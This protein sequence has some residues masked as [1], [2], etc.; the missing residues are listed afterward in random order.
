MKLRTSSQIVSITT[1]FF[2]AFGGFAKAQNANQVTPPSASSDIVYAIPPAPT[3]T[4]PKRGQQY[5]VRDITVSGGCQ[6]GNTVNIYGGIVGAPVH[7]NCVANKFTRNV[8]LANWDGARR[9]RF[10]QTN[11]DGTS[12][13]DSR[14]VYLD[15]VV[16]TAPTITAP[17]NNSTHTNANLTVRGACETNAT[18]TIAGGILNSPVRFKCANAQYSR[19]VSLTSTNGSKTIRL[20]QK[21]VAGNVSPNRSIAV[22]LNVQT[23]GN[24]N[25]GPRNRSRILLSGHSLVD[26][27]LIDYVEDIAQKT[28]NNFNYNQQIVIGSPIRVR[29]KGMNTNASGWPGYST[30]KNKNTDNLNLINEVRNPQTLG[31]GEKYDTLVI[32]ENHS[33]LSQIQ[34]ENTIKY[35]RHYQDLMIAGNPATRSFF[36]HSWL[37][38]N[39]SNPTPWINHEKN[40]AVTWECVASKVNESLQSLNRT[41]RIRL[42]PS[43]GAL[44]D[45]VEKVV[46]GQVPGFTGSTSARLN[47]IFSDN[48]HLTNLGAYY[49]ALVVFSSVYGKSAVG[50]TP[51]AGSNVSNSIAQS[52]QTIAWNYVNAYYSQAGNPTA[53]TMASCRTFIANNMCNTYWNLVGE[54]GEVNSCRNFY[55]T[56]SQDNPFGSTPL[57]PFPTPW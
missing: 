6:T 55:Q 30:G 9:I 17:A 23:P 25:W 41:D 29:T 38:V 37:D 12:A 20:S 14:M 22:T 35:L 49:V 39:K 4:A 7:T 18:V 32:T 48:V 45:L 34:W 19:Q 2:L 28:S 47:M 15:R 33:S 40:A 26:N 36:Y 52:L 54:P 31:A 53:R 42:L 1:Y 11:V 5:R 46:A 27:P 43:G 24:P 51:P 16:P 50:T 56:D 8:T 21:D 57:V 10:T 44:V 3:I 13:E